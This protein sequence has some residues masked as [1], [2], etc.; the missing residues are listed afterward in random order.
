MAPGDPWNLWNLCDPQNPLFSVVF[1]S[2]C[3]LF[4]VFHCFFIVFQRTG[5]QRTG[6]QRTEFQETGFQRTGFQETVFQE[7]WYLKFGT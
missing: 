7:T 5:S 4:I 1:L 6:F 3:W 2:F